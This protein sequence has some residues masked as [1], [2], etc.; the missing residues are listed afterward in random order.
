MNYQRR[1]EEIEAAIAV[2]LA[3]HRGT[4][5]GSDPFILHAL[6]VMSNVGGDHL[7]M[8]VAVLHDVLE[9]NPSLTGEDLMGWG[10]SKEAVDALHAL[11]KHNFA[12]Y[13]EYILAVERYGYPA[14]DVKLADLEDNMSK[15][16]MASAW[17]TPETSRSKYQKA[18]LR[19]SIRKGDRGGAG[20][21]RP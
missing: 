13:A 11:N 12:D 2:A 21:R 4:N 14:L 10:V 7:S 6:R 1:D 5:R 20:D 17:I 16:E 9:D 8:I 18:Y 19:L 3:A 15:L